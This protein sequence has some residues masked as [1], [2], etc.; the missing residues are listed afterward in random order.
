MEKASGVLCIFVSV[1][2]SILFVLTAIIVPVYYSAVGLV[3]PKAITTVIQ[4]IDYREIIKESDD[5]NDTVKSLGISD[6]GEI[7][8]IMKSDE[9][10][11]FLEDCV[12][13]LSS[14]VGD[15]DA[16]RDFDASSVKELMNKHMDSILDVVEEKTGENIDRKT[17]KDEL[18][19]IIDESDDAIEEIVMELE[20]IQN[21]FSE[22]NETTEIVQKTL[23][24]QFKT[25]VILIEVALLALIYLLRKKN[26]SGFIWIAVNT[27][28]VGVIMVI[29]TAIVKSDF[30][31]AIIT[32]A[33]GF[34]TELTTAWIGNAGA[35]FIISFVTCFV[36]MALSITA[37]VL[38]RKFR[39]N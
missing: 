23:T 21:T 8:E 6:A 28:I 30:V 5:F 29:V 17:A 33:T 13:V 9:V 7:D 18:A 12:E 1:I 10:G 25:V 4:N 20:P 26:Y 15:T 27:G 32:D 34:S 31:N 38:L 24:W 11:E 14:T 19:K 3:Q 2:L 37:C 16:L 39:K 22:Y 36:I 35:K